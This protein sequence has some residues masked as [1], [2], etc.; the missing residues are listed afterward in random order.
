VKRKAPKRRKKR[1]APKRR[2]TKRRASK[3]R[4]KQTTAMS[5]ET[6]AK[7]VKLGFLNAARYGT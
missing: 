7:L 4:A 6:R 3:R 5:A 2:K 1:K